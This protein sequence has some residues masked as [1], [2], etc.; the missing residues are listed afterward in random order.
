MKKAANQKR[1]GKRV[2]ERHKDKVRAD[3]EHLTN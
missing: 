3:G 1:E 2:M